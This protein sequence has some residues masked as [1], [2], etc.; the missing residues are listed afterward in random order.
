[1]HT[2][3]HTAVMLIFRLLECESRT[4]SR[5]TSP[6]LC[7]VG[8]IQDYTHRTDLEGVISLLTEIMRHA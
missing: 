4:A 3:A 1:M 5:G 6:T 2:Q 7:L 8:K